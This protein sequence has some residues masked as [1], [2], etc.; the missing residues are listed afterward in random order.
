MNY[1]IGAI[2]NVLAPPN[3][4][5]IIGILVFITRYYSFILSKCFELIKTI[6]SFYII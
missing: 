2:W 6:R 3:I 4:P 5:N 1:L